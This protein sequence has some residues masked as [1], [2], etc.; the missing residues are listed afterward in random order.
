MVCLICQ[1]YPVIM[2]IYFGNKGTETLSQVLYIKQKKII[3]EGEQRN[4]WNAKSRGVIL[5]EIHWKHVW[6]PVV[7]LAQRPSVGLWTGGVSIWMGALVPLWARLPAALLFL[8]QGFLT[9]IPQILTWATGEFREPI[10]LV[11][12]NIKNLNFH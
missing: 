12:K 7:S 6:R 9:W 1:F 8:G 10:S 4:V 11:R 2:G 3:L 5:K